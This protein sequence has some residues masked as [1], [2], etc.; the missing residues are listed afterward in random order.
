M[1]PRLQ[2]NKTSK[3]AYV[4]EE[5]SSGNDTKAFWRSYETPPVQPWPVMAIGGEDSNSSTRSNQTIES[6]NYYK[7]PIM[8]EG[9]PCYPTNPTYMD[10]RR[11]F[12]GPSTFETGQ[13]SGVASLNPP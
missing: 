5:N 2:Q 10:I 1:L 4:W 6:F 9:M 11:R 3:P 13:H 8:V 7:R 12:S